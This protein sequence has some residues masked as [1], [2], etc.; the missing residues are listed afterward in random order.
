MMGKRIRPAPATRRSL[1][2][3]ASVAVGD[4]EV[5]GQ[6][7]DAHASR[8]DDGDGGGT[9]DGDDARTG[10]SGSDDGGGSDTNDGDAR[11][12][13]PGS[14]DGDGTSGRRAEEGA[15]RVRLRGTQTGKVLRVL[16]H[17]LQGRGE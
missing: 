3:A 8:S 15:G 5:A 1:I 9:S 16:E 10:A 11:A 4:G 13:A 2:Q 17:R 6:H 14:D 7:A 12:D